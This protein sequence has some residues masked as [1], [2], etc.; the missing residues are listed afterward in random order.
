MT[1]NNLI[2]PGHGELGRE[3]L[4]SE[5]PAVDGKTT[6]LF[7]Q[8]TE[9]SLGGNYDVIYKLLLPRESLASDIPAG[10]GNIEKLFLRC[11]L[12]KLVPCRGCGY[13]LLPLHAFSVTTRK[14]TV[15]EQKTGR[16]CCLYF[17]TDVE[18]VIDQRSNPEME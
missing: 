17:C 1:G 13:S 5:I 7:L 16:S 14:S 8:C 11:T 12:H 2:F 18:I 9:L 6:N 4:V 15:V 3:I 10:D